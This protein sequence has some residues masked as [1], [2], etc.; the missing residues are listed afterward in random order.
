MS[1]T[2]LETIRLY[3]IGD[4][5]LDAL[6]RRIISLAWD[7]EFDD[8]ELVDRIAAELVYIK[9]GV[10]DESTFR[11]RVAKILTQSQETT[12]VPTKAS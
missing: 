12:A 8:Q 2:I 4:T 3:L 9:D 11:T 6:E 1:D 7:D 10:S 5:D